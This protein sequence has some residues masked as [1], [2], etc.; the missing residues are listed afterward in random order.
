MNTDTRLIPLTQGK[1]AIVD[2]CDYDFLI[3]WKWHVSEIKLKTL[4]SIW[5]AKRMTS[6]FRQKGR[7]NIMMHQEIAKRAGYPDAPDYDHKDHDGLNNTRLNL[8][9]CTESQN[10]FNQRKRG[11]TSS[12]YKGLTWIPK[13]KKWK[14]MICVNGRNKFIGEFSDEIEAAKAYDEA[15]GLSRPTPSTLMTR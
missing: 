5:Y 7:K 10:K 12:Q 9:A 1:F 14:V 15:A 13:R 3:Q 2:A 6:G 4:P 8:R 11:G